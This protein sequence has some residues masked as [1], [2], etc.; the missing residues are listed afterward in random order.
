MRRP[1]L[2]R[3]SLPGTAKSVHALYLTPKNYFQHA[4]NCVPL[5]A[6]PVRSDTLAPRRQR[7]NT[8]RG[9]EDNEFNMVP[10]R[11]TRRGGAAV[12]TIVAYR[13]NII[14]ARAYWREAVVP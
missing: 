2:Q 12:L 11:R 4:V 6:R 8:R 5:G 1:R 9:E 7:S 10:P 3:K 13:M 14:A